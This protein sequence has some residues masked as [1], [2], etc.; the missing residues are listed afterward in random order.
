MGKLEFGLTM[1]ISG[2]GGTLAS[3][4]LLSLMVVVLKKIFPRSEEPPTQQ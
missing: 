4:Y 2:I 1:F 3:L